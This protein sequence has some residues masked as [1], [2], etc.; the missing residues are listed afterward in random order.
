[1][2]DDA[3]AHE[4]DHERTDVA[5]KWPILIGA[6]VLSLLPLTIALIA[7]LVNT[8]WE[9]EPRPD[10]APAVEMPAAARNAPRLQIRP[11]ADLERLQVR[12]VKRLHGI[13][14]VD[15]EAGIVHVPIEQAKAYLMANGL[16]DVPP[17]VPASRAP[18]VQGAPAGAG[19]GGEVSSDVSAVRDDSGS[20][21]RAG[22]GSARRARNAPN[23]TQAVPYREQE[24]TP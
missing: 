9:A 5:A 2:S 8:I 22:D 6:G 24:M 3:T 21:E 4:F 23:R 16:P 20:L 14:W 12:W 19:L 13:G 11:S 7:V 10:A 18:G 1:M 15:R 17:S